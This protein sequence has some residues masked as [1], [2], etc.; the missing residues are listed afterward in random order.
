MVGLVVVS[1]SPALAE[2]AVAL[3]LEMVHGE[4]P[5]VAIAAGIEGAAFGTDAAAVAQ[6]I[7]Q[8]DDGT[9]VVVL[10]DLGSAVL[11]S[12][13][14]LELIEPD[15][16]SRVHLTAAPLV[17]GLVAAVVSAA[18][19]EPAN[20]VVD[21]AASGLLGKETQLGIEPV[22][23]DRETPGAGERAVITITPLHGLHARPAAR[24]VAEAQRFDATV[25]IRNITT[26]SAS[27]PATSLSR[28]AAVGARQGHEIELIAAGRQATAALEAIQALAERNF[29]EHAVISPQAQASPGT[30]LPAA[31]GIAVG[32]KWTINRGDVE[33]PEAPESIDPELER[34]SLQSAVAATRQ[35]IARARTRLLRNGDEKGAAI[36]AA[37]LLMLEDDEIDHEVQA[38]IADGDSAAAAWHRALRRVQNEWAGLDDP[39]MRARTADVRAVCNQVLRHLLGTERTIASQAGI[40]VAPDLTPSEIAQLEANLVSGVATAYGAPTSHSAILARS[41][42][43][44]AVVAAGREL[45]DVPDGTELVIDGSD[46]TLLIAP[47][48]ET[49]RS[50]RV[51]AEKYAAAVAAAQAHAHE[52]AVTTDG[53]VIEVGANV[54]AAGDTAAVAAGGADSLALL[55]T[56]FFFIDRTHPPSVTEQE[57]QYRR[58]AEAAG[59]RRLTIRTLDLGGDKPVDYLPI[60]EEGN[61]FLGLRGVRL[62]LLHPQLLREQLTAIVRVARDHPIAVMFPMVTSVGELEAL[63]DELEA[64]S[65]AERCRPDQLEMGIMVEVPAVAANAAVFTS[66]VDFVSI[67]TNDLA[68]YALAVERGNP[69]V[70][71]LGDGLDPGMLRLIASVASA[72]GDHTRVAVCGELASDLVA[73]PLLVGLGVHELDV[74][75]FALPRVKDEIRRWAR[76]DAAE[77]AAAAMALDSAAAVRALVAARSAS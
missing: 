24:L 76:S 64:V 42:G 54:T 12:E 72:A 46:G 59:G 43:I 47:S 53:T 34:H 71:H 61:P 41:L 31:P 56:E 36:F 3:A 75:R 29:D 73:I 44:P 35:E 9:G 63:R 22:A 28:V 40:L 69:N 15:L 13:L 55:R 5:P 65:R 7:E 18:A 58:I 48:P 14:A 38:G 62:S 32:P 17:E 6:A 27:A 60:P 50:Y 1:H 21:E 49:T 51:K 11:S 30:P 23:P 10:M 20:V 16:R 74:T 77:L 2:A 33:L 66:R 25:Q 52:P 19:G 70:A 67:G 26:G 68:Q 37:H 57:R 39:Y 4:P 45:L 8:I